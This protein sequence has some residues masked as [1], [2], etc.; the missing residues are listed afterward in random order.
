MAD[1]IETNNASR[2]LAWVGI[3]VLGLPLLYVLSTGPV[4]LFEEKSHG[5]VVSVNFVLSFYAPL[6]WLHEHTFLKVPLDL[7]LSLWGI[8]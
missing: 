5:V 3:L 4:I 8:K 2:A 6:V 7:Y 1:K